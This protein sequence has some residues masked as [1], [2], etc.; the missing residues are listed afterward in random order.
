MIPVKSKPAVTSDG[1]SRSD[2]LAFFS[3]SLPLF[4][5]TPMYPSLHPYA[6]LVSIFYRR[7]LIEA[8]YSNTSELCVLSLVLTPCRLE[9]RGRRA[10]SG[11]MYSTTQVACFPFQASI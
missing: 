7:T 10:I 5:S 8:I 6:T 2:S 1:L 9:L 3:R 4:Y 11:M